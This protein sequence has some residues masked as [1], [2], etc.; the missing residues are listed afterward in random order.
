MAD[1]LVSHDEIVN[2]VITNAGG[3]VFKHTGDGLMATFD[4]AAAS[5]AAASEIQRAIGR[6][7]W[8]VPGGIRVR[9][10]LHSGSVHER[11]DDLFGPPV[12]RLARLLSRCSPGAVIVSDATAALL[13]D[14]MPTGLDTAALG[15]VELRG[16]GRTEVVHCLVG[17]H[18]ASVDPH[19]LA[20]V[21]GARLGSLPPIED[22]LIGRISEIAAVL[23]SI[24]AHPVVSIVGVGGMGKT[25]VAL[26][27]ATSADFSGGAWW[28]DLTAATTPDAV[29]IAVL[30]AIGG[31]PSPGQSATESVVVHLAGRQAL[32]VFD[33]CEHVLA[34]A[35]TLVETIRAECTEARV[36]A[37][38]REAFGIRGEHV[39][40]LSPLPADDAIRL[41]C[42][43]ASAAR[44]DLAL[45]DVALASIEAICARLDG[46]PL[47]IELAATRCRS[48][49]PREI[50]ARLDNRFR[51]LRGGR[52]AVERH[53]TL[54][55]AVDWSYSL[56]DDDERALLDRMSVF[57][58]G[59]SIDAV[60]AV[61]GL[62]EYD[63]LDVVDR[64]VAQSMVVAADTPL[65][66]RYR[67]LETLRQFAEDRLVEHHGAD[68]A[69]DRHLAWAAS[70]AASL[71]HAI[72]TAAEEEGLR[73]YI[74]ELDNIRAAVAYAVTSHRHQEASDVIAGVAF[75]ALFRSTFE[76]IEWFDPMIVP[77]EQW[78]DNVASTAGLGAI[79]AF[80]AGGTSRMADLLASIPNAH[81]RNDWV[82]L[83]TNYESLFVTFDFD[84][85]EARLSDVTPGNREPFI[86]RAAKSLVFQIRIHTDR[87][88]DADYAHAARRHCER[89]ITQARAV[90]SQVSLAAALLTYG[91]CLEGLHDLGAAVSVLS[92]SIELSEAAG[93]W[94][95]VD[96][97]RAALADVITQ[98]AANDPRQL[99]EAVVTLRAT[100]EVALKHRNHFVVADYL[101]GPV[102]RVLWIS[103][104][105]RHAALLGKFG[106]L[107]MPMSALWPSAVDT[108]VLGA[109]TMAEI[110]ADAAQL[111]IDTAGAIALAALDRILA[112]PT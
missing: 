108:K 41:F 43:R 60:A 79:L 77:A 35:R 40:S 110:L 31:R 78:T 48:M 109:D 94:F 82:I 103:G 21:S 4:A 18:L 74:A 75:D 16:V 95:V 73:R 8:R 38:S 92:E 49:A 15:R 63:A 91:Y 44:T 19:H 107:Q 111:N 54:H 39:V 55:A 3:R 58:G 28:C 83:A 64:L 105:H 80:F 81:H 50:A 85:A 13:A 62:D 112:K 30:A 97:S 70:L 68:A 90:G 6:H 106:R 53:Q 29:A 100:V 25:R 61:G 66:T 84:G 5:A 45:D 104:D 47:A 1:D 14:G 86:L 27:A 20:V 72:S 102:E 69:R 96:N 51:L 17:E 99:R 42:D 76:V 71:N 46:I 52:H 26:E 56:L 98:L 33:N 87:A 11:D 2:A 101:G 65:G 32:V 9:V 12:N 10:S 93:A 88:T 89:Y 24:G 59:A 34:A 67:Q 7:V 23:G 57:R 22:E 36:L 37:T